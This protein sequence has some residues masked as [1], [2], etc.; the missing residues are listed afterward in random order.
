VL[1]GLTSFEGQEYDRAY[2]L[3]MI[4]YREFGV[5]IHTVLVLTVD[6]GDR[7]EIVGA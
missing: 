3:V 7:R 6:G 2:S 4:Q 5:Q 1:V